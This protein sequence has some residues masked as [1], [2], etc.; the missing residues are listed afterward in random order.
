MDIGIQAF[1]T[2]LSVDP[3]TIGREVEM[4]G[5]DSLWFGEHSHM[6][7]NSSHPATQGGRVPS[8]YRRFLDP[9]IAL[10][11]VGAATSTLRLGTSV[12][13]PAE[14][15][16]LQLAK[17][18][19]SL[20][21]MTG[22]RIDFGV[23]YGWNTPE[24]ANLGVDVPRRRRVAREKLRAM[25]ELWSAEVASFDG[26]FVSFSESWAWPKPRQS[27]RPPTLLGG[28]PA[29]WIFDDIVEVGDGWLPVFPIEID[30]LRHAVKDL[31]ARF[32]A[33]PRANQ[34]PQIVALELGAGV[35]SKTSAEFAAALPSRGML[36]E[37]GSVGVDRLVLSVPVN[38]LAMTLR[39]LD[40]IVGLSTR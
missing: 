13:L 16:P 26:E 19:A 28:P 40:D 36:D 3:V 18:I 31:L 30:T 9:Y 22:G 39:A 23:G 17:Q 33:S 8:A 5:L 10:S 4:R 32:E 20:D 12:G 11:A 21:H 7:V 2:D 38:S 35:R 25:N 27:P 29:G 6:P 37:L 1:V 24:M 14:H 34:R 15:H